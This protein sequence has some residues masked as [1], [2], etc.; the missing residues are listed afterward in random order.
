[1]EERSTWRGR[2]RETE[3]EKG[4]R[5]ANSMTADDEDKKRT[6]GTSTQ[7]LKYTDDNEEA[8]SNATI[9]YQDQQHETGP[10]IAFALT[11]KP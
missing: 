7:D 11:D 4:R 6:S 3:G 8:G 10:A 2:Q 5:R 9:Y 1:M